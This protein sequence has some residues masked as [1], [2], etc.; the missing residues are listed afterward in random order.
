VL[1]DPVTLSVEPGA[2]LLVSVYGPD[3]FVL[4][5]NG[6]S[7]LV[8][9]AGDQTMAERLTSAT[10]MAGRPI[11]SGISVLAPST[12]K[13]V[14]VL[15]D[16]ITDGNRPVL[17]ALHS[18]P[19]ELARRLAARGGKG[20]Y[21]VANA[22]ISG[23]RILAPGLAAEMGISG[24]ARLDRDVL[25]V[26]GLSHIIVLEGINDIGTSGQTLFGNNP[27]V[28]ADDLIMGYRQIIARGHQRGAKV[29]IGTITPFGGSLSHSSPE[30][31]R[32]RQA[33]N[34][35]IRTSGEPD[36]VVDFESAVSDPSDRSRLQAG[37]DSGDHLHP[38][39]AG[40]KAMGDAV[41][42]SLFD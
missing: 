3:T 29:V 11:V 39:E 7:A 2:S 9:A 36:G 33:V 20:A 19:E 5:G 35:W 42:L 41:M 13:V 31:E 34:A 18:W 14:V 32:T 40:L 12:T 4:T 15:G 22:G 21:A 6:A 17:T 24:L 38:N 10:P 23:N 27:V 28:T 8:V 26:E 30:K 37:F 16:S 1:S 25:R